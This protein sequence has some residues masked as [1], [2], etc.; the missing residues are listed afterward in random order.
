MGDLQVISGIKKLNNQNYNMW[1]LHMELYFQGK[2]LWE[3]VGG[4]KVTP[5][6]DVV[7]LKKW[8]IKVDK[9]MFSVKTI[10]KDVS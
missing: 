1:S 9:A 7:A 3:I 10:F 5:S 2:D 6:E 8:T 4:N